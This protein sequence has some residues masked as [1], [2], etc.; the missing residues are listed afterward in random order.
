MTETIQIMKDSRV[1]QTSVREGMFYLA[2]DGSTLRQFKDAARLYMPH[3]K[4]DIFYND[5]EIYEPTNPLA[6]WAEQ[7]LCEG[8]LN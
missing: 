2:A 1:A 3:G 6:D 5:H 4:Y 7:A 8:M